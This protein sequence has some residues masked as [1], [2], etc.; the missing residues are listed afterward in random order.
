MRITV[1]SA[2]NENYFHPWTHTHRVLQ[3]SHTHTDNIVTHTHNTVVLDFYVAFNERG[4]HII[5]MLTYW[6]QQ[7]PFFLLG[8]ADP[9]LPLVYRQSRFSL[10]H[11]PLVPSHTFSELAEFAKPKL[12]P[13]YFQSNICILYHLCYDCL[14]VITNCFCCRLL[15][16]CQHFL[17]LLQAKCVFL[18]RMHVFRRVR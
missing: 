15:M 5:L 14:K 1:I 6:A 2:I 18:S 13:T 12:K 16:F 11:F 17:S 9:I 10:Q 3:H 4:I 7:I 8:P